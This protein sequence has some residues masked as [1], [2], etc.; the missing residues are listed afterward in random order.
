[1][2]HSST[3][4]RVIVPVK[5][6]S[7]PKA[8]TLRQNLLIEVSSDSEVPASHS[9]IR[10]QSDYQGMRLKGLAGSP[11]A[12][13]KREDLSEF[14]TVTKG[15]LEW[16]FEKIISEAKFETEISL[17]KCGNVLE[18][19]K[20][21]EGI[22]ERLREKLWEMSGLWESQAEGKFLELG[23]T[24]K[25]GLNESKEVSE[26]ITP[27]KRSVNLGLNKK[28]LDREREIQ[29]LEKSLEFE[30]KEN[31]KLKNKIS[32]LEIANDSLLNSNI[33]LWNAKSM[34]QDPIDMIWS[35]IDTEPR[36]PK[37][38]KAMSFKTPSKQEKNL[39][40]EIL[41]RENKELREKLE[42]ATGSQERLN[43]KYL[44]QTEEIGRLRSLFLDAKCE[45]CAKTTQLITRV[46]K[47]SVKDEKRLRDKFLNDENTEEMLIGIERTVLL[48]NKEFLETKAMLNK[49]NSDLSNVVSKID[50]DIDFF[51][52]KESELKIKHQNE[53]NTIQATLDRIKIAKR[54]YKGLLKEYEEKDSKNLGIIEEINKVNKELIEENNT[55]KIELTKFIELCKE[56][57]KESF[58]LSST[59]EKA[60]DISTQSIK[61]LRAKKSEIEA[62]QRDLADKNE[63]LIEKE[64]TLANAENQSQNNLNELCSIKI[65]LE[66]SENKLSQALKLVKDKDT[67]IAEFESQI[68]FLQSV[69]QKIKES[70]KTVKTD[71]IDS[72]Q[73]L[74]D[75]KE[76]TIQDLTESN[77]SYK[78]NFAQSMETINSLT[79][80]IEA[81][82]KDNEKNTELEMQGFI[83]LISYQNEK[84]FNKLNIIIEDFVAFELQM[85]HIEISALDKANISAKVQIK[86][87]ENLVFA[88]TNLFDL[89]KS[90]YKAQMFKLKQ[91]TEEY[92]HAESLISQHERKIATL[93][94]SLAAQEGLKTV[95]MEKYE[96]QKDLIEK[97]DALILSHAQRKADLNSSQEVHLLR[98][99]HSIAELKQSMKNKYKKQLSRKITELEAKI[100]EKESSLAAMRELIAENN[101]NLKE[102]EEDA[103]NH[104][105]IVGQ[106]E[107][108]NQELENYLS[109]L[110]ESL[111]R[112][113][114]QHEEDETALLAQNQLIIK[115]ET[116]N[117]ELKQKEFFLLKEKE[118][119]ASEMRETVRNMQQS[120]DEMVLNQQ[121]PDVKDD[122]SFNDSCEDPS[123]KM[124]RLFH[125]L[126]EKENMI[127]KNNK[128]VMELQWKNRDLI[129][130]IKDYEIKM[131][132]HMENAEKLGV[133]C[134]KLNEQL[135]QAKAEIEA[136]QN[137][138][139]E[140][141]F[142]LENCNADLRTIKESM[143]KT[144][145][146]VADTEEKHK[147][148][149]KQ[150]AEE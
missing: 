119:I 2:N 118:S 139:E 7:Q 125:D 39:S 110:L 5:Q 22:F 130:T 107:E 38:N 106:L 14:K 56:K 126:Q 121:K 86:I 36:T 83:R 76:K 20:K 81:K 105:R 17:I 85:P 137:A 84:L 66:D 69:N 54:T 143:E 53:L 91:A 55:L 77:D 51:A 120:M 19:N 97:Y 16:K 43:I 93:E 122:D 61:D 28:I 46:Y 15:A 123:E 3:A 100:T 92:E 72:Y 71:L 129:D 138:K 141:Q 142:Q 145:K 47:L 68:K 136:A 4:K 64:D 10:Q 31:N 89:L 23:R 78:K 146:H 33:S 131:V 94:T 87:N 79:A 62:L 11:V 90:S 134:E 42:D 8:K 67:I 21:I 58:E 40:L 104:K 48:K 140:I 112:Y 80:R 50:F 132:T 82:D 32:E 34:K 88:L 26:E 135:A 116:E 35:S 18:R 59:L 149:R 37:L 115:L 144:V 124:Q 128:R 111:D 99:N 101:R 73:K 65:A 45:K 57:T 108:Q 70:V 113:K 127:K 95:F 52:K 12:S 1:M 102:K 6:K 98:L 25:V 49:A 44:M 24:G 147:S 96:Y 74:M 30:K 109:E 13:I 29:G 150:D 117:E 9:P 103:E 133:E 41:L 148:E 27:M 60:N 75:D 63:K 114:K